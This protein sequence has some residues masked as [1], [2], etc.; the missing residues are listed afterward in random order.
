MRFKDRGLMY[1]VNRAATSFLF[2]SSLLPLF[3]TTSRPSDSPESTMSSPATETAAPS[4]AATAP[5]TET[6]TAPAW[7]P[8]LLDSTVATLR[9]QLLA[10]FYANES[11]EL[12]KVTDPLPLESRPFDE[13]EHKILV[14]LVKLMQ[15]AEAAAILP[16]FWVRFIRGYRSQLDTIGLPHLVEL[17]RANLAWRISEHCDEMLHTP[18]KDEE[19]FNR[20]R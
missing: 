3:L 7:A 16:D 19:A 13:D 1:S 14:E 18:L 8:E 20:V 17:M 6:P 15:P 10:H 9:A 11:G 2:P 5:V 12:R 4:S